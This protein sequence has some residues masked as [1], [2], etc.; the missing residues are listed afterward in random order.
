MLMGMVFGGMNAS[1]LRLL[2][3]KKVEGW[4]VWLGS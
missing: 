1:Y 4:H 2:S 3:V